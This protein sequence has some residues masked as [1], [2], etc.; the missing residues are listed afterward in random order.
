MGNSI[1]S[2]I[3]SDHR[4]VY[5]FMSL[6]R[7]CNASFYVNELYSKGT[8]WQKITVSL[9]SIQITKVSETTEP[10]SAIK[11]VFPLPH[12][13]ILFETRKVEELKNAL[14]GSVASEEEDGLEEVMGEKTFLWE[15][16][17]SKN[18]ISISVFTHAQINK[19]HLL[20]QIQPEDYQGVLCLGDFKSRQNKIGANYTKSFSI[21]MV[22]GAQHKAN[23]NGTCKIKIEPVGAE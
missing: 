18:P 20:I 1:D 23:L 22:H 17:N 2:V 8:E 4:P 7:D 15:T 11:I 9:S 21:T 3:T 14:R 10:I 16:V 6:Q 5:T 19:L 13:D 12:E